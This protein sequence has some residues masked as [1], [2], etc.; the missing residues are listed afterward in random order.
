MASTAV[1]T[2]AKP[3]IMMTSVSGESSLVRSNTC[4]P[5]TCCIF[6]SVMTRS[7]SCFSRALKART[8]LSTATVSY[9][10]FLSTWSRFSRAISSSSTMRI[11]PRLMMRPSLT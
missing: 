4:K 7:N 2:V 3:V 5:S 10:S 11:L 1:D 9:P 6:R 8:P